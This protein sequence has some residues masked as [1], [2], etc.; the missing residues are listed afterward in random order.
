M[1]RGLLLDFYGTV[2]DEDDEVVASIC[3]RAAESGPGA[4]TA[5]QV[6][7]AW[8]RA[9]QGAMGASPFRPQ[10][11]IAVASLVAALSA[12]GCTADPAVLCEEQFR[13]WRTAPL[14]P[15]TRAFLDSVD[16]PV[17]VVSNIDRADLEAVLAYHGLSFAAIVTSEDA[18]AYKPSPQI[19]RRGLAMLGL[20][21]QEVLHVGDSLTADVAG[22]RAAG[23]AAI[24]VNRRGRPVPDG[25]AATTVIGDLADLAAQ[26]TEVNE[27]ICGA[28]PAAPPGSAADE[29]PSGPGRGKGGSGRR[30]RR[31]SPPR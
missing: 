20:R 22:A 11:E 9:F 2:V 7:A 30:S 13:F 24:W 27:A 10:R 19:F 3:A 31:S 21:A 29:D 26:V 25:M 6:G 1:I 23:I 12:T 5:E 18:G 8:G 15:G 17:C 16:M 14:R 4:V 28:R